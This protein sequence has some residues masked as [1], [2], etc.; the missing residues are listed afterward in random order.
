M[1]QPGSSARLSGA[2]RL[3]LQLPRLLL[4]VSTEDLSLIWQ[5]SEVSAHF[6]RRQLDWQPFLQTD[7]MWRDNLL[8]SSHGAFHLHCLRL[9]LWNPNE[10]QLEI[11]SSRKSTVYYWYNFSCSCIN[12]IKINGAVLLSM[13][14]FTCSLDLPW[15][16][17]VL[18]VKFLSYLWREM[19]VSFSSLW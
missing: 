6:L 9:A 12:L 13:K 17:W 14:Y 11:L 19:F 7:Y 2:V 1:S 10:N 3:A 5:I 4:S 18:Q 16:F 15:T 8:L